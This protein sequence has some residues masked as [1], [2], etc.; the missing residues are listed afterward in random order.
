MAL[1]A[2]GCALG[3]RAP[4]ILRQTLVGKVEAAVGIVKEMEEGSQL[5]ISWQTKPPLPK[6]R[7]RAQSRQL[8]MAR[9]RQIATLVA[10]RMAE[11]KLLLTKTLG[12]ATT[13]VVGL[14]KSPRVSWRP[15]L[16]LPEGVLQLPTLIALTLSTLRGAPMPLCPGIPLAT[17]RH[18]L[19]ALAAVIIL[20][21][22]RQS[23][24]LTLEGPCFLHRRGALMPSIY[25]EATLL[26]TFQ[27][28]M[29]AMPTCLT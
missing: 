22:H 23:L 2:G 13:S 21:C 19:T 27:R 24:P 6:I 3:R 10:A 17:H 9:R 8:L 15:V 20:N 26:V 16:A 29:E 18:P 1:V 11:A 14:S 7:L 5:W 4:P 28:H 12:K 25:G